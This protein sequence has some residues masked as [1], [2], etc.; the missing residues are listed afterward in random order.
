MAYIRR[1]PD[2]IVELPGWPA[3]ELIKSFDT[4]DTLQVVQG[5]GSYTLIGTKSLA[6]IEISDD[7]FTTPRAAPF[8]AT[9]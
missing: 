6:I 5:K 9:D 4:E 8:V 7:P 1:G 2:D 3:V